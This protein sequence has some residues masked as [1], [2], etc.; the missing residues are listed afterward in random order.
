MEIIITFVTHFH[1][2]YAYVLTCIL[3]VP[4]T[5][6]LEYSDSIVPVELMTT[7]RYS[8]ESSGIM[9]KIVRLDEF[10]PCA[11]GDSVS[12]LFSQWN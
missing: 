4:L 5:V 9:L 8:P 7:H 3:Y 1:L 2:T 10:T 6:N 11:Y 12:F